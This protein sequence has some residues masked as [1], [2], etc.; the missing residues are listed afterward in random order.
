MRGEVAGDDEL[1]ERRRAEGG[2][3]G[4]E[5]ELVPDP[6]RRERPAH[7]QTGR[8]D[9][10]ERA[11]V[12]DVLGVHRAQ[13]RIG[14]AVEAEQPVRVVLHDEHA[15]ASTELDDLRAPVG[16]EADADRVVEVRHR[17]EEL[18][19]P[20]L[21]GQPLQRL[22]EGGRDQPVVVHRDVA[23]LGLVRRER[24]Q[25]PD[26]GRRLGEHDVARVDEQPGEHVQRRLGADGDHHVVRRETAGGREA[27]RLERHDL[28]DLLAQHRHTLGGAVLQGALTLVGDEAGDLDRERVQRE[29]R[30]VRHPAGERDDLGPAGD[31][32]QR[33]DLRGGH[34][35]RPGRVP[36]QVGIPGVTRRR[37]RRRRARPEGLGG[38][39]VGRHRGHR[40]LSVIMAGVDRRPTVRG[41]IALVRA[42]RRRG[43][44]DRWRPYCRRGRGRVL[45]HPGRIRP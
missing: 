40:R 18:R 20:A 24:A 7:P 16:R 3:L 41:L 13:R 26:V 11:E 5:D 15:V 28:A 6:V 2:R 44:H 21:A 22:V 39:V 32:E 31:R 27:A 33:A 37:S 43:R 17:V 9:L 34:S 1:G 30:E 36:T 35:R 4:G 42:P 12:D 38:A 23:D 10:R 45:M 14:L 8:E 25:R 19:A 29:R